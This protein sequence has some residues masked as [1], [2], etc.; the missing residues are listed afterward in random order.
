MDNKLKSEA[1]QRY[2]EGE[3]RNIFG[4]LIIREGQ[5][6]RINSNEEY[7]SF[8]DKPDDWIY[9]EDLINTPGV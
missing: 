4:G 1:L 6:F 3:N 7:I 8:K 5:H 9:F 2:I